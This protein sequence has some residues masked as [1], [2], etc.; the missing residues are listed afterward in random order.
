MSNEFTPDDL[1]TVLREQG[2]QPV[3]HPSLLQR[4]RNAA[5]VV[6]QI[7]HTVFNDEP[8]KIMTINPLERS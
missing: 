4:A 6:K 1:N 2:T 7:A 8:P 3:E 5:P